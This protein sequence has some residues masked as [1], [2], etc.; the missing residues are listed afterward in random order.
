MACTTLNPPNV[1][2][3]RIEA[4]LLTPL[5][6]MLATRVMAGPTTKETERIR[7]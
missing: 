7:N 1:E 6:E 3:E 5:I 2:A 4:V